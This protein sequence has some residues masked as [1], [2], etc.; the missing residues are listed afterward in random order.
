MAEAN[1]EEGK[2]IL[3]DRYV[4]LARKLSTKYLVPIP[5]EYANRFCK[6]CYCYHIPLRTC[7]VRI[8]R[9]MIITYCRKCQSY[10]R[11]PLHR[12]VSALDRA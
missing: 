11:M 6:H 10:I 3:A 1:A 8:H 12:H 4:A 9:G 2:L 5:P 7:R